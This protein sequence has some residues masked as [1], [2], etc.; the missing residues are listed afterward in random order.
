MIRLNVKSFESIGKRSHQT[1]IYCQKYFKI[2]GSKQLSCNART[3]VIFTHKNCTIVE[4]L[5][6]EGHK[7]YNGIVTL[8]LEQSYLPK[9]NLKYREKSHQ[10]L[11]I[12]FEMCRKH[13]STHTELEFY[14]IIITNEYLPICCKKTRA[15]LP[16]D[17][18]MLINDI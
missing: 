4:N 11:S 18:T 8:M 10:D 2:S 6:D 13:T 14:I 7:N 16:E 15:K 17:T 3:V 12:H 1:C 9:V 5:P